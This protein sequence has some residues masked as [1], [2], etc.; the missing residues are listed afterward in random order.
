M[1]E[2]ELIAII[3]DHAAKLGRAPSMAELRRAG[4]INKYHVD[5]VFGGYARALEACGLAL[6]G[7]GFQVS[8]DFLF[9]EWASIV[10]SLGR[11]PRIGEYEERS[12]HSVKPLQMRCKTWKQVP[13]RV[14]EY[15]RL[16]RLGGDW[17]DVLDIILRHLKATEW[18][19][20][21]S[22][23]SMGT[24]SSRK[25]SSERLVY[26]PPLFPGSFTYAPTN[27][28]GVLVLFATMARDLGF[29]ITHV[30]MEF[31]DCEAMREVERGRWQRVRIEFEYESRNFLK[32]RHPANGCDLI[33]CWIHNW[34]ECPLEVL[35]LKKVVER[36]G[37]GA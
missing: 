4:K 32:H 2:E 23:P 10:R 34:D 24:T 7:P 16:G 37:L 8:K 25:I 14:L 17:D 30:Q 12:Q 18:P 15:A 20:S 26:G 6:R 21:T 27:E 5:K 28:A 1:S 11:I 13:K 22:G 9:K 33:V 35:E 36:A 29:A 31:P 3:K 19:G